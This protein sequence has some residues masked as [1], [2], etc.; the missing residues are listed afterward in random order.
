M[1]LVDVKSQ[2][3]NNNL[4]FSFHEELEV[5]GL[6]GYGVTFDKFLLNKFS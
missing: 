4:L 6:V 3:R 2:G 5:T 1:R